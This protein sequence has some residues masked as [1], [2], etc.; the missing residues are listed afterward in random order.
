LRFR[1]TVVAVK[2]CRLPGDERSL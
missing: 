1:F 2:S